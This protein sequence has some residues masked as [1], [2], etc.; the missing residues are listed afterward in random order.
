MHEGYVLGLSFN[1]R[2]FNFVLRLLGNPIF[3]VRTL[4]A[5]LMLLLV[6]SVRSKVINPG[7]FE[8]LN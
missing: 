1:A 5:R 4:K 2:A 6:C 3:S 8:C 7:Q